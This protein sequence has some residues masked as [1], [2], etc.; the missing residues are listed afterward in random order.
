KKDYTD[1]EY[2]KA[3]EKAREV[4]AKNREKVIDAGGVHI[5]GTERHEARRI[6]NQLRGRSG[7][8]GDPGTSRFYLSLEDDLMR[9]FGS[10]RISG[11]MG[12]LGMD[13]SQPIE[14]RW[15]TKAIETSQ[16]RVEAHNFDIRKHLL[17]YDDVNNKQR[18][19]IYSFRREILTSESLKKR[20]LEMAENVLDDILSMYCSDDKHP[21]EW[22]TKGL[23]DA[24]YSQ[25]SIY[26]KIEI[27]NFEDIRNNLI[28]GIKQAY[29]SKEN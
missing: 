11:L 13:E 9:I 6:D 19:E 2:N 3:L 28:N 1:D 22:D 12:K 29:E 27:T 5:L 25:F 26:P 18:T 21:E 23:R 24:L 15:V 16:K 20:V 10:D 7:R 8:Q 4:C 17:E 14:H